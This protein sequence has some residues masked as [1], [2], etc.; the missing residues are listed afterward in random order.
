VA[1]PRHLQR[2]QSDEPEMRPHALERAGAWAG[3]VFLALV[4]IALLL[5]GF[6]PPLAPSASAAE[7]QGT[8]ATIATHPAGEGCPRHGVHR[9]GGVGSGDRDPD[10]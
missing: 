4:L 8:I 9:D 2:I 3:P 6:L 10:A 5:A 7:I 1:A